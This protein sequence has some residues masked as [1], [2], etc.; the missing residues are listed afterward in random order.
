MDLQTAL[1]HDLCGMA[2]RKLLRFADVSA[3]H[4][5]DAF[6]PQQIDPPL[7]DAFVKLHVGNPVHQQA[8]QAVRPL[9]DGHLVT[10]LIQLSGRGQ[11]GRTGAN[12]G[13]PSTGPC[14]RR[15]RRD[16]A[17]CPA[18]IDD[19]VFDIL[20][21]HRRFDDPQDTRAFAGGR[22]SSPREFREVVRL[23]QAI[24]RIA[25]A[26]LIHQVVPLGNQIVNRA[27]GSRLAEWDAT[28]HA[29][30]S[31]R[32]QVVALRLCEDLQKIIRA[33]QRI[34]IGNSL[35]RE[36]FEAS[37]FAHGNPLMSRLSGGCSRNRR[38]RPSRPAAPCRMAA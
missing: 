1:L 37:R 38:R 10:R 25:P 22:A 18:S 27:A 24:Q 5:V 11:A 4:E 15:M 32:L 14:G 20:D 12:N 36:F 28:I 16:P 19:R 9:V 34:P 30:R 2:R 29:P 31:L 33:I 17:F 7:D 6:A 23:V 3:S 21:R 13:D 8:A 26:I 35:S